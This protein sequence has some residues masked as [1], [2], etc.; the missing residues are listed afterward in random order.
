[1]I[2]VRALDTP[3]SAVSELIRSGKMED[4]YFGLNEYRAAELIN[5]KNSLFEQDF[6]I[7]SDVLSKKYVLLSASGIDTVAD[8]FLNGKCIAHTS[9]MFRTYEIDVKDVIKAGTNHICFE[10]VPPRKIMQETMPSSADREIHYIPSGCEKGNQYLRKAHSMSGWD[11]G[12]DLPDS[13]IYGDV[14]IK[15]FDSRIEDVHIRQEHRDGSV[16]IKAEMMT[17]DPGDLKASEIK[18]I[19]PDMKNVWTARP[20]ETVKIDKPE[21]WWPNNLGAQPLYTVTIA[22]GDDRRSYRIGLRTITVSRDETS[23]GREFCFMVNG[24]RFFAMGADYIPDD[25]IYPD[26][27]D[28]KL[29]LMVKTARKSNYNMIRIWGGGY[30]PK[31]VFYDLCDRY[32][33][34]I[35]QDFMFACNIYDGSPQF[36][37]DVEAEAADQIKRLRHHASL[38]MWCGNNEIESAWDHWEGFC[39]HSETLKQDYLKIFEEILPG[40]VEK[41]DGE[42]FYWPSSPSSGGHFERP[43][44]EN[45]GDTHYWAVWHGQLPFSDYLKHRF[46]FCSEFGFQSFPSVKTIKT[47]ASEQDMNIFSR[48]MESHQKNDSA[49]GKMLFY[50]SENFQYPDNFENVVYV[51]QVLQALAVKAGVEHFRRNRGKCMGSLYWQMNDKWPVASWSSIDYFGR[52][53]ALQYYAVGFYAPVAGSLYIDGGTAYAFAANET[54]YGQKVKVSL[55]IKKFNFDIVNEVNAE[56]TVGSFSSAEITR[57]DAPVSYDTFVDAEF[58]YEDGHTTEETALT[59]PYKHAELERPN[60]RIN[61]ESGNIRISA[62]TYTPFVFLD[63]DDGDA[64]FDRNFFCITGKNEYD[65][66]YRITDGKCSSPSVKSLRDTY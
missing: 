25:A 35:W 26:I 7:T 18:I 49:N 15:A 9:D 40:S 45:D 37:K 43:D 32:G 46:N 12:I 3:C 23:W 39:D 22:C 59:V 31:D 61:A 55:K 48:V 10:I 36:L 33:I 38:G 50:I 8:I 30:Y 21:L 19:S 64:V 1:M 66:A 41:H 63:F 42:H 62:D 6:E 34:V 27:T 17:T 24:V 54:A 47:Y 60:L 14:S 53:K 44:D 28:E 11:W 57:I 29:E 2:T 51:T 20:G 4:P 56:I 58:S 65:T 52:W 13:G 16:Y 5:K